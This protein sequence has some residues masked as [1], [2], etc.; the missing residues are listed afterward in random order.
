MF[1]VLCPSS[2]TRLQSQRSSHT[3]AGITPLCV[4]LWHA[5]ASADDICVAPTG[6]VQR[7]LGALNHAAAGSPK[8]GIFRVEQLNSESGGERFRTTLQIGGKPV[9]AA[10]MTQRSDVSDG[11]TVSVSK[12]SA[13]TLEVTYAFG[14][15]GGVSC[16]YRI[17]RSSGR[18]VASKTK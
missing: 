14:G 1:R 18:F 15:G 10:E 12:S 4:A 11:L 3:L 16:K 7:L 8:P 13:A 2:G 9:Y 17:Y 6:D 5:P